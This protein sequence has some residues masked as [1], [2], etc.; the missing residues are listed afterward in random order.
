MKWHNIP[1]YEGLYQIARNG[2]VKSLSRK[3]IVK[4][5]GFYFTKEKILVH[6]NHKQKDFYPHVILYKNGIK[7]T[8]SIH[9]LLAMTFIPNPNGY[10]HVNHKNGIKSDYKL[11][12]LEWMSASMN[13]YHAFRIGLKRAVRG[14][15]HPYHKV[16]DKDVSE[17]RRKWKFRVYTQKM[18]SEEYGISS[19]RI[20]LIVNHK[21]RI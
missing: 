19:S 7:K 11:S 20:S 18:L 1:N 15:A 17:M 6:A 4:K 9:R 12:N 16:T 8:E 5:V 14:D 2:Q 10:E 3:K 21:A 13:E